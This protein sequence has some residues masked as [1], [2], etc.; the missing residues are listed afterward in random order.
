[1]VQ[2]RE[3]APASEGGV[4]CRDGVAWRRAPWASIL[5]AWLPAIAVFLV[6]SGAVAYSES[7]A[8]AELTAVEPVASSI[9]S[10]S[11][12][13]T[14]HSDGANPGGTH[15][16]ASGSQGLLPAR[17]TAGM[18]SDRGESIAA[19]PP[20]YP[21][22][23]AIAFGCA[24]Q[25]EASARRAS[26]GTPAEAFRTLLQPGEHP[27]VLQTGLSL[28]ARRSIRTQLPSVLAE[29]GRDPRARQ[30]RPPRVAVR[31]VNVRGVNVRCVN[32]RCVN[33]RWATSR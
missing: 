4:A 5:L 3:R 11:S 18:C 26:D 33:V 30:P 14:P 16:L 21:A 8:P 19:P 12:P 7:A 22:G 25:P 15:A 6:A 27:A 24:T 13:N 32:V 23:D 9:P 29:P 28:P 10:G 2:P 31:R 20:I 1:M 17:E